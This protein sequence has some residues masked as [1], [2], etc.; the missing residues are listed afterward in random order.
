MVKKLNKDA[1]TVKELLKQGIMMETFLPIH[2]VL[3]S[4]ISFFQIYNVFFWAPDVA[5]F[6]RI[7]HKYRPSR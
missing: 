2:S 6:G 4:M 3:F 7:Q 1:N 5:R